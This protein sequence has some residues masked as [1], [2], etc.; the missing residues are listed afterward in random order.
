MTNVKRRVRCTQPRPDPLPALKAELLETIKKTLEEGKGLPPCAVAG[1]L[2]SPQR[3]LFKLGYQSYYELLGCREWLTITSRA[4]KWDYLLTV[5]DG[6]TLSAEDL[7]HSDELI[8]KFGH[9][10]EVPGVIPL[11][12]MTLETKE[13]F[14]SAMPELTELVPNRAHE[15]ISPGGNLCMTFKT[16]VTFE[17]GDP[18]MSLLGNILRGTQENNQLLS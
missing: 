5:Q 13:G 11:L 3:R 16:P 17:P 6:W 7:A 18:A 8:A 4:D 1:T 15:V 9:I 14:W 2:D 12:L 10:S